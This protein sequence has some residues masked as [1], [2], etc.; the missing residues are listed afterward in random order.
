MTFKSI[1]NNM[2]TYNKPPWMD[3]NGKWYT[4]CAIHSTSI[5]LDKE[6]DI[7]FIAQSRIMI[8]AANRDVIA[9]DKAIVFY[10]PQLYGGVDKSG[11]NYI[12]AKDLESPWYNKIYSSVRFFLVDVELLK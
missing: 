9:P 7:D 12:A 10:E 11:Y 8:G 4:M 5:P 3:K 1:G 2:Y 6:D